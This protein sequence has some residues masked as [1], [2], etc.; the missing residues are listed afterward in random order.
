MGKSAVVSTIFLFCAVAFAQT[1]VNYNSE[2]Y[3]VGMVAVNRVIDDASFDP[4]APGASSWNFTSFAGGRVDTLTAIAYSASIPHI[5][6]YFM[7]PNYIPYSHAVTDTSDTELWLFY[8]V[9]P[10]GVTPLGLY[11]SYESTTSTDG[12]LSII[13]EAHSLMFDFPVEYT[14]SWVE[15]SNGTGHIVYGSFVNI[16]YD[17]QDT[18]WHTVDGYG[19]IILPIGT[20]EALRIKKFHWNHSHSDHMLFGFDKT[21]RTF[22]YSWICTELGVA[23]MFTG[24]TDSTGGMPDSM[25]TTGNVSFQISN[26]S[27]GVI[28]TRH[29]CYLSITTCPNPFNSAVTIFVETLHATSLQIEVFDIAG[30]RV[31]TLRPSATSLDKGGTEP[32]PLNKGDVAQRQGVYVWQPDATIGSGVYLVRAKVGDRN[33]TK[34][35]VYL[36]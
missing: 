27:L 5:T 17:Y 26:S 14:D 20:F 29:P 19:Q 1:T 31:E 24:P 33:I 30:R 7:T 23:A 9:E 32:V 36:K 22:E 4:G 16:D 18:V 2:I 21:K 12:E 11:G 6:E 25:F 3:E 34:R 13:D 10:D 8:R 35:I 15:A 28:E